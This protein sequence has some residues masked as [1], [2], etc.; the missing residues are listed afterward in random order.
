MD[1]CAGD[2][3]VFQAGDDWVGKSIAWLTWRIKLRILKPLEK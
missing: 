2:I 1:I 3:F